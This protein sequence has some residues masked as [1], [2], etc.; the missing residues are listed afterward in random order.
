[1][2]SPSPVRPEL[3]RT[4]P[5]KRVNSRKQNSPSPGPLPATIPPMKPVPTEPLPTLRVS[6]PEIPRARILL[7][8]TTFLSQPQCDHSLPGSSTV[9]VNPQPLRP[10]ASAPVDHPHDILRTRTPS[11]D[12][13]SNTPYNQ[14]AP[15]PTTQYNDSEVFGGLLQILLSFVVCP[16]ICVPWKQ[17]PQ[18]CNIIP[19][20]ATSCLCS[21]YSRDLKSQVLQ[22][23]HCFLCNSRSGYP[24]GC[25]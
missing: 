10:V 8:L 20:L 2:A 9:L 12:S 3:S 25:S 11:D 21:D 22:L 13:R 24:R 4:P 15:Y 5:P 1:M 14:P 18:A 17:N 6:I 16:L 7:H 23:F 19:A